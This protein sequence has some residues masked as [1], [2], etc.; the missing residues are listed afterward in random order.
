MRTSSSGYWTAV[1]MVIIAA[2]CY[3]MMTPLLKLAYDQDYS[4]QQITVHQAGM[5]TAL[6]WLL[7]AIRRGSWGRHAFSLKHWG[8]LAVTG[9]FGLSLTTICYNQTL[10]RLDASF[11]IVLL[12][13]FMWITIFLESLWNRKWPT[14]W[15]WTAIAMAMA[16][17]VLAAGLLQNKL[18][19]LN[20]T[21]VGL[22]LASAVSYS[23]F[24]FL[25]GRVAPSYDPVF[26]SAIMMSFGLLVIAALYGYK[27]FEDSTDLQWGLIGW[28][29]ALGLL[30]QVIPTVFF[31]AGIPRIGSGLASMLGAMELPFAVVS[32][33]LILGEPV[34][35]RAVAGILLILGG[36]V[37]AEYGSWHKKAAD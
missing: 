17:T 12:F 8:M 7:V 20:W 18:A 10:E 25:A 29:I 28:G 37:L 27:S 16:G 6:L 1:I 24:L 36:I 19:N 2:A 31:N 34:S 14:K 30:G 33:Y 22:G 13:Q 9:I 32:A 21:G 3:G 11:S 15:Q 4:F 26:K 35:L 5:G 23:L